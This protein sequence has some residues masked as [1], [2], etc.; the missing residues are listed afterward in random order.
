VILQAS[1]TCMTRELEVYVP[2]QPD[3]VLSLTLLPV[4]ITGK[5]PLLPSER[6]P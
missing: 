3:E 2:F 1:R 5:L 4:T 6:M